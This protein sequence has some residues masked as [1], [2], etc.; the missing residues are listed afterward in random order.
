MHKDIKFNIYPE[1]PHQQ[2]LEQSPV[3]P[4]R[5]RQ[6]ITQLDTDYVICISIVYNNAS[7]LF[8]T[9]PACKCEDAK[10]Y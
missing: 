9:K 1:Q 2:R 4:W 5:P 10:R 7:D 3:F 8:K 6:G